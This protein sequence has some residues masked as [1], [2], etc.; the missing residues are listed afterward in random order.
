MKSELF[1]T[2]NELERQRTLAETEKK[3]RESSEKRLIEQESLN[4]ELK[5]TLQLQSH[6]LGELE[7]EIQ[8][9]K[10][11]LQSLVLEYQKQ[12]SHN[13]HQAKLSYQKQSSYL[14]LNQNPLQQ[15]HSNLNGEA[16]NNSE[17]KKQ[18]IINE[19]SKGIPITQVQTQE[20]VN[21][22]PPDDEIF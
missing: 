21:Q 2:K 13:Y 6:T 3:L 19:D 1:E 15:K 7:E 4:A 18:E 14:S 22:G 8:K 10:F 16:E 12:R 9:W 17:P 5:E 20:Q 11:R